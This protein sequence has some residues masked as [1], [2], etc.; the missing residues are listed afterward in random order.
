MA[1]FLCRQRIYIFKLILAASYSKRSRWKIRW[2]PGNSFEASVLWCVNEKLPSTTMKFEWIVPRSTRFVR[3]L[4][5]KFVDFF[6]EMRPL[7]TTMAI[8]WR[9][10]SHKFTG[11]Q[12]YSS[13]DS[14]KIRHGKWT[15][16]RVTRSLQ[17]P[18]VPLLHV[19]MH[20][21]SLCV[22]ANRSMYS[23]DTSE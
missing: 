17:I 6:C 5:L 22:I 7:T 21:P 14:W 12:A 3:F 19:A 23:K 18:L 13:I 8:C 10:K 1:V 9:M 11:P 2:L 15:D 20:G 16:F 4:A